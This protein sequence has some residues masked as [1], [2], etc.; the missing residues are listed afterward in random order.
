[1]VA[2]SVSSTEQSACLQ[3]QPHSVTRWQSY[4]FGPQRGSAFRRKNRP[5]P[6]SNRSNGV[7][8]ARPVTSLLCIHQCR[9]R[10]FLPRLDIVAERYDVADSEDL[11]LRLRRCPARAVATL[12]P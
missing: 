11:E 6:G 5:T 8:D 2:L 3:G 1:M 10:P 12:L 4:G 9:S 7:P